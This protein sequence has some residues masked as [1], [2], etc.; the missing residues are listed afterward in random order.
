MLGRKACWVVHLSEFDITVA[1]PNEL[2]RQVLFDLLEQFRHEEH[3]S[4]CEDLTYEEVCTIEN[5]E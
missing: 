1:T 3:E 4:L 5:Y 2:Q